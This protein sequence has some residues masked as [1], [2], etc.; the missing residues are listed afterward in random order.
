MCT[1]GITITGLGLTG[2]CV[3]KHTHTRMHAH[4]HRERETVKLS[5]AV[6]CTQAVIRSSGQ[7]LT[8]PFC[9]FC[10]IQMMA[11]RKALHL[12]K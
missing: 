12:I 10:A 4:T 2:A 9:L 8:T 3:H 11:L 5:S 7:L 6:T 1:A